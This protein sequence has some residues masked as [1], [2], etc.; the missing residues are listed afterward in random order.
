MAAQPWPEQ[1]KSFLMPGAGP[2]SRPHWPPASRLSLGPYFPCLQGRGP[3]GL[4]LPSSLTSFSPCCDPRSG[5]SHSE[6]GAMSLRDAVQPVPPTPASVVL[7]GR[8]GTRNATG[9]A[10]LGHVCG[11]CAAH[12]RALSLTHGCTCV[13]ELRGHAKQ[14]KCTRQPSVGVK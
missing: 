7:A 9:L 12:D 11:T 5:L 10:S 2:G 1:R 13:C 6:S 4:G 14:V 3:P 8:L